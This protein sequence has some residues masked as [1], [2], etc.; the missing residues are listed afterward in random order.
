MGDYFTD[1][2]MLRWH[3][4]CTGGRRFICDNYVQRV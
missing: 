3:W 4:W 1:M 2:A